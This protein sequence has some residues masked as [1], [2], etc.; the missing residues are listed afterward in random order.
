MTF[1][2]AVWGDSDGA[3]SR[4]CAR[5][6]F[7]RTRTKQTDPGRMPLARE[8]ATEPAQAK[9]KGEPVPPDNN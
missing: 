9:E 1:L 5:H 6:T 7:I 8:Q 4:L 3:S 2:Q